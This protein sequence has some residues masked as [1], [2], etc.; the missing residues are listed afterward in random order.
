[1]VSQRDPA[2][3]CLRG[4]AAARQPGRV[5]A[6]PQDLAAVF[7]LD[8]GEAYPR[9]RAAVSLPDPVAVSLPDPVAVSLP[10]LSVVYRPDQ[11]VVY[12][13]DPDPAIRATHRRETRSSKRYVNEGKTISSIC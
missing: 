9:D 2:E 12:P 3:A 13:P 11:A 4:L 5:G 1:V 10:D 8:L 6:C 7:P